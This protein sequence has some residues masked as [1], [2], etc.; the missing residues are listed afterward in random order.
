MNIVGR[1]EEGFMLIELLVVM[2]VIGI[3]ATIAI[4]SFLDQKSKANDSSAQELVH[5]AQTV[6]ETYATD[7]G[8][9]YA[10]LSPAVLKQY[11][12]TIQTAVGNGNSC[13]S[14]V[15]NATATRLHDHD[16]SA[17]RQRDLQRHSQQ[18]PDDADLHADERHPGRLQQR[19]LVGARSPTPTRFS[20][21]SVV[22][23]RCVSGRPR[24]W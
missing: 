10:G 5:N 22:A 14:G 8:G 1:G 21:G 20:V 9:S 23:A 7:H 6:A 16:D 4:P 24:T 18:R 15:T 2:V 17:K 11:D 19:H 3:L 13:V 12:T